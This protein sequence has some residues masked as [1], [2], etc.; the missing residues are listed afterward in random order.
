MYRKYVSI[1][2]RSEVTETLQ[3]IRI[4]GMARLNLRHGV[5]ACIVPSGTFT[6]VPQVW[7]YL[8]VFVSSP[9]PGV[10]PEVRSLGRTRPHWCHSWASHVNSY[11]LWVWLNPWYIFSFQSQDSNIVSHK[12]GLTPLKK[13]EPVC[14]NNNFVYFVGIWAPTQLI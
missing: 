11:R 12:K 2:R 8:E 13:S 4:N 14:N 7:S 5:L 9:G 6:L 10:R 3:R 1:I